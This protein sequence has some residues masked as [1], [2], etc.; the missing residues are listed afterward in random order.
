MRLKKRKPS[1]REKD[2]EA[3]ELLE[4]LRAKL[5]VDDVSAAR[6]AA[7][8]LSWKQEDGLD[9]LKEALFID[10]PRTAKTAAAYGLRSMRGR[11]KKMAFAVLEEGLKHTKTDIREACNHAL[12]L[13]NRK[14]QKPHLRKKPTRPRAKPRQ[15]GKLAI[16]EIPRRRMS[17]GQLRTRGMRGRNYRR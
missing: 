8:T 6:R 10:S 15:P 9:I 17:G 5:Y 2:E 1:G 7:F 4:Q 16:R 3:I 13:A 11:M 12:S 14:S